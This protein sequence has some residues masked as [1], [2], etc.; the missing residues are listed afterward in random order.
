M[1]IVQKKETLQIKFNYNFISVSD[2][3]NHVHGLEVYLVS[4]KHILNKLCLVVV[5][6]VVFY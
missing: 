3:N 5:V 4:N 1:S 6:V 2:V